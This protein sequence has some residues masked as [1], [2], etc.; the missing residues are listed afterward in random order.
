M[1]DTRPVAGDAVFLSE[2]PNFPS[3]AATTWTV[4]LC[5]YRVT[6]RSLLIL[7]I[8]MNPM[9]DSAQVALDHVRANK[10]P[11]DEDDEDRFL[12]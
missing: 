1:E 6:P 9:G 10:P 7:D 5:G 8:V 12:V 2:M 4:E 3:E 11:G